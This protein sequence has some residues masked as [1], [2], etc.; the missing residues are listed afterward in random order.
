[1]SIIQARE[2]LLLAMQAGISPTIPA[3]ENFVEEVDIFLTVV[4]DHDEWDATRERNIDDGC[5]EIHVEHEP[6][7]TVA[8]LRKALGYGS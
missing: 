1:M 6:A 3:I 8:K 4:N 7:L 5:G 2:K